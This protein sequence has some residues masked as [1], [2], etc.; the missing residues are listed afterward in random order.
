LAYLLV[1]CFYILE[2][3]SAIE[4]QRLFIVTSDALYIND[5]FIYYNTKE[6][7]FQLF[8]SIIDYKYI[9]QSTIT[10]FIIKAEL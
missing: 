9:K 6:Y 3:S 4:R 10:T 1:I 5:V 7:I 8:R 2:Y